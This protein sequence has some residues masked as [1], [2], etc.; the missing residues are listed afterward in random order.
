[1]PFFLLPEQ[2]NYPGALALTHMYTN[3]Y[4][5]LTTHFTALFDSAQEAPL[6]VLLYPPADSRNSLCDCFPLLQTSTLVSAIRW[7]APPLQ[8]CVFIKHHN[9]FATRPEVG[10]YFPLCI[11]LELLTVLQQNQSG[12]SPDFLCCIT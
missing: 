3:Q 10:Q 12:Y 7:S 8:S 6:S 9:Y 1:M 4:Q 11:S 5:L 2:R